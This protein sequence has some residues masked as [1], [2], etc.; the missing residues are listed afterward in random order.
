MPLR[1]RTDVRTD[2]YDPSIDQAPQGQV[3]MGVGGGRN[4]RRNVNRQ[5]SGIKSGEKHHLSLHTEELMGKSDVQHM[6]HCPQSL[7]TPIVYL[8]IGAVAGSIAILPLAFILLV[9]T[10]KDGIGDYCRSTLDEEANTSKAIATKLGSGWQN[11][12]QPG[13]DLRS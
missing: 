8:F 10:I 13:T 1:S 12:N 3:V 2:D 5:L 6:P 9:T 11:V 4:Q 7:T